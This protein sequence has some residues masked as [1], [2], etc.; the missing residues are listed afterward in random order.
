MKPSNGYIGHENDQ[1]CEIILVL[2]RGGVKVSSLYSLL[3]CLFPVGSYMLK[4]KNLL[5]MIMVEFWLIK[6][7]KMVVREENDVFEPVFKEF[8]L[9]NSFIPQSGNIG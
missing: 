3:G 2:G 9:N 8:F 5:Q 1:L 4:C 6:G 7:W